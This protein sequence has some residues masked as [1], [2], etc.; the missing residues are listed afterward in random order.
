MNY[1]EKI[2][3]AAKRLS[4]SRSYLEPFEGAAGPKDQGRE[5]MDDRAERGQRS[6][7]QRAK[8]I[9]ELGEIEM[10]NAHVEKKD[11]RTDEYVTCVEIN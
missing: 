5:R 10:Y 9:D 11:I 1:S 8:I 7:K 2:M 4:T 6:R 3:S